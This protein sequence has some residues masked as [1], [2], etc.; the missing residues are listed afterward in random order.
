MHEASAGEG[1]GRA[2]LPLPRCSATWSSH[3]PGHLVA[4]VAVPAPAVM[5]TLQSE[6]RKESVNKKDASQKCQTP[7]LLPPH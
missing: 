4:K 5:F 6:R 1:E 2:G 3:S 7:F